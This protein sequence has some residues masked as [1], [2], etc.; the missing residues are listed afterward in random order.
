M[1]KSCVNHLIKQVRQSI[2]KKI[3]LKTNTNFTNTFHSELK[4]YL[5][6][7]L[8]YSYNINTFFLYTQVP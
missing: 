2:V 7:M 8:P 3:F 6:N 1:V 5:L 4:E